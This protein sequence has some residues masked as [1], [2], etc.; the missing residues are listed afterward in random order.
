MR[1]PELRRRIYRMIDDDPD[2]PQSM[3][4]A[5]INELIDEALE[6][7]SE[8]SRYIVKTG[9]VPLYEGAQFY[10]ASSIDP[11]CLA[12]VRLWLMDRERPLHYTTVGELNK[13]KG[14]WLDDTDERPHHW[15]SLDHTSFGIYPRINEAS[16]EVLRVDYHAWA[17]PVLNDDIIL[18][19][20]DERLDAVMH[21]VVYVVY[22]RRWDIM[23]GH[24][25]FTQFVGVFHDGNLVSEVRR[26]NRAML[27][28]MTPYGTPYPSGYNR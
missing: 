27:M 16:G 12:P 10:N 8:E 22:M 28:R 20:D 23:R 18:P 13:T 25:A 17:E 19:Y 1:R 6:I 9:Y 4:V 26:F 24:E 15:F 2:N 11:L 3:T 5:D 14:T 7:L 21:Y